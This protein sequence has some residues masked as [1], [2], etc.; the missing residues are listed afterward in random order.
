MQSA[1]RVSFLGRA[2]GQQ[3]RLVVQ[4]YR[5]LPL[6]RQAGQTTL[7]NLYLQGTEREAGRP[8]RGRIRIGR[9]VQGKLSESLAEFAQV[10]DVHGHMIAAGKDQ[11]GALGAEGGCPGPPLLGVLQHGQGAAGDG[12]PEKDRAIA[13]LGDQHFT[14][15]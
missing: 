3:P 9:P 1:S 12:A 14:I 10:P 2:G 11:A 8:W 6:P 5:S 4:A 7:I 13:P 15:G